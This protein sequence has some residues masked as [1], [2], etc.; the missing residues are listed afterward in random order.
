M[1]IGYAC[2][3]EGLEN[4][5]MKKCL[6]KNVTVPLLISTIEHNLNSLER[7]I[8]YNITNS[9][10]LFRISSDLI[11]FG[12]SKINDL[13]WQVIFKDK[14]NK[15][16]NKIRDNDVRVSM[17]PGQYTVLNSLTDTT[18]Q[19]AV[20][21]LEYHTLVLDSLQTDSS[22]KI[23]LHVG[24]VYNNKEQAMKRFIANSSKLSHAVRRRLVIENDDKSYNIQDVLDIS[25]ITKIPVVYDNLHNFL[26]PTDIKL[27]D[28]EWINLCRKTWTESDGKQKIHYS[29]SNPNKKNGSH[30]NTIMIDEFLSFYKKLNQ[31]ID[32]MLEVKDKNISAIKCINC[33]ANKVNIA[34]IEKEWRRYK[35]LVLS[36]S[37]TGYTKIRELLKTFDSEKVIIF[38]H[39]I[40]HNLSLPEDLGNQINAAQHVWGYFKKIATTKEKLHFSKLLQ[41]YQA[42]KIKLTRIK[43]YLY[44]LTDKYQI[45]YL[46]E[47]YYFYL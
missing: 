17:H 16:A 35:Y 3:T 12:S 2:I 6:L 33:T 32:I 21:D 45:Q 41:D 36:K 23:I 20:L 5:S 7:Q 15:I 24:G 31:D 9:I 11:P 47:S 27:S 37:H 28:S 43:N 18:V 25:A 19:N 29:Q 38:Y 46:M 42:N 14:L 10:K 4:T 13:K 34:T 39:L 8:D 1:N 26:N 30:S 44:K 40:E 22:C